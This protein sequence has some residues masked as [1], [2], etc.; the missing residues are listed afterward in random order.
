MTGVNGKLLQN[1]FKIK[2][3]RLRTTAKKILELQ[4]AGLEENSSLDNAFART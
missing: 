3:E 1:A 4:K 2:I